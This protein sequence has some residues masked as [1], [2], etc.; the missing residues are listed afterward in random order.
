MDHQNYDDEILVESLSG[1]TLGKSTKNT[2]V[3]LLNTNLDLSDRFIPDPYGTTR[4]R[5]GSP[6]MFSFDLVKVISGYILSV[7]RHDVVT[8]PS[9]AKLFWTDGWDF[10]LSVT[11][12]SRSS[13]PININELVPYDYSSY[14]KND[15]RNTKKHYLIGI[16]VPVFS[17]MEYLQLFMKSLSNTKE[18]SDNTL[19]IFMDESL[20]KDVD[21][22]KKLV[23][24]A[25]ISFVSNTFDVI[26]IHK[27][28]H[29]NMFNSILRGLD[30][31]YRS[32]EYLST[33]DSDT[34][35]K[36][37]W[38][39]SL[40]NT[41]KLIHKQRGDHCIVLSGFNTTNTGKHKII[42]STTSHVIKSTVGGC[43]LFFHHSKY[44]SLRHTLISH[45]WDTNLISCAVHQG[46]GV[47]T[48]KPSIVEH[49]GFK[50]SG[51]RIGD[52][53]D[54]NGIYDISTDFY[55]DS[56]L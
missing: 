30:I 44:H 36:P 7:T 51:H 2:M 40:V 12:I 22:D 16:V 20:T 14:I 15:K 31:C 24:N 26:K 32:C 9:V 3:Y 55:Q 50:S 37:N 5:F 19:L 18:L 53:K 52:V 39:E 11:N 48:T 41:Y 25:V 28:R 23:N 35:H 34:I 45:K 1:I 38:L 54:A 42:K 8:C 27:K 17:R 49:I 33:V 43:H 6:N 56:D 10:D 21:N 29:G 4:T 47:Y 13:E 46:F